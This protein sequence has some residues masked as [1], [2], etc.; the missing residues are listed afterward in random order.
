[1]AATIT[2]MTAD[3]RIAQFTR[4]GFGLFVHYG[5]YSLIGQ[6]EWVWR[7]RRRD[8][9]DYPQLMRSF[10]ADDFDADAICATA[11]DAGCRYVCLT[12]RHHEGFSLYDTRGLNEYDAPHSAAKR[13]L[14]AEFSEAC[15][16]HGIGKYFYHTTLD[17]WHPDFDSDWD[18]YQQYLRD[19]VAVLCRNYGTWSKRDRDWQEDALYT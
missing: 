10:S 11:A 14:V 3:D 17:W 13:D 16:R 9:H 15:E 2:A 19:S 1:M 6:G 7:H 5:L 4:R 8:D 12:T 18:A